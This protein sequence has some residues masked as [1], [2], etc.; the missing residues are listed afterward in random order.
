[1]KQLIFLLA[2]LLP[3]LANASAVIRPSIT[4][5]S[6]TTGYIRTVAPLAATAANDGFVTSGL[7]NI[8]GRSVTIPASLRMAANAGTIATSA[9]R[10][11]PTLIVGT[12]AAGWLLDQGLQYLDDQWMVPGGVD[13][14]PGFPGYGYSSCTCSFTGCAG[15]ESYVRSVITSN[16]TYG[17]NSASCAGNGFTC[18]FQAYDADTVQWNRTDPFGRLTSYSCTGQP[19]QPLA[20]ASDDYWNNLPSPLPSILPELPSAPYMPEGVPV[21][22]PEF[23]PASVPIGDPYTRPDG[24]TAQPMAKITPAGDGQITV[25]TYD[26]PLTDPAGNPVPQ[27]PPEDTPEPERDPCLDNPDRLGCL[28]AGTD[29]FPVPQG[30]IEFTFTPEANPFTGGCPAPISVL[31]HSISYQPA[32]DAMGLV[33]PIVLGIASILAAYIFIGAFRGV[34]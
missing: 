22:A 33:R 2:I 34:E 23:E 21:D 1:M 3:Q 27:A 10:L 12:L 30:S 5:Y 28:P 7:V 4:G 11:N 8:G 13:A 16:G 6:P 9:M 25:D 17:I 14:Y 24:S 19:D 20:P 26:Q 31:G 15:S 18:E 32:C 29:T